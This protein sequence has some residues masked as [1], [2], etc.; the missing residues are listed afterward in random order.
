MKKTKEVERV[1]IQA[2]VVQILKNMK[3][4][5]DLIVVDPPYHENFTSYFDQFKSKLKSNGQIIWFVQPTEIYDL[6]EK[7]KQI[8]VWKEPMSPKPMRNKY[9][10]FFDLIAWYAYDDYTFNPL[11]WNLMNGVFEDVVIGYV[12]K[13]KWQKPKTLFEKLILIHTNKG[14][15]IFDPFCGSGILGD[16]AEEYGRRYLGIDK[17]LIREEI[18]PHTGEEL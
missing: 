5:F 3:R 14:D 11:L 10:E 8:L 16:V 15:S 7:P 4:R 6:P 12:R 18:S 9:K 17:T 1:E 2:D 13:H